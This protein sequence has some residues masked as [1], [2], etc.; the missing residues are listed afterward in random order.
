MNDYILPIL[1]VLSTAI[2]GYLAYRGTRTTDK[3]DRLT[4]AAGL[5]SDYAEKMEERANKLE[6]DVEELRQSQTDTTARLNDL[7][8]ENESYKTL[9]S[10]VIKWITELLDWET[11][12][13]PDPAPRMTLT[14]ILAHL[15]SALD[16]QARTKRTSQDTHTP[17]RRGGI[18][19]GNR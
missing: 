8:K 15:T 12:G 18:R 4:K 19:R 16:Q 14:M 17:I 1:G 13:Y 10:E 7:E 9:I 2:G 11:R 3:T 6:A 5:Y